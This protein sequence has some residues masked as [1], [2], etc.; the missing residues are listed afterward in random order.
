[1]LLE[2]H[3]VLCREH[4]P[5]QPVTVPE[6]PLTEAPF[7]N[8]QPELPVAQL[9]YSYIFISLRSRSPSFPMQNVQQIVL[10]SLD[11]FV[12]FLGLGVFGWLVWLPSALT[13]RIWLP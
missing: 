5:G 8:I 13:K 3:Q 10:V 9:H 12:S 4:F 2:L 7:P 11:G 6:H 1:M